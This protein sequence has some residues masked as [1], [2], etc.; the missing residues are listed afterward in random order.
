VFSRSF[1]RKFKNVHAALDEAEFRLHEDC[2]YLLDLWLLARGEVIKSSAVIPSSSR[3]LAY[4]SFLYMHQLLNI[5][6]ATSVLSA[7]EIIQSLADP[8]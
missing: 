3:G 1:K 5:T 2:A 8:I 7:G 6:C 4:R